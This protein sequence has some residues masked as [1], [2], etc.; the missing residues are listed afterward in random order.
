[1]YLGIRKK[2]N[3]TK[4]RKIGNKQSKKK[5]ITYVKKIRKNIFPLRIEKNNGNQKN[6][7]QITNK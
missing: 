5:N 2:I 4:N 6:R 3:I 7:K 1:M